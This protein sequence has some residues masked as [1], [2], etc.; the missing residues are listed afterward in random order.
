MELEMPP[1]P[2]LAPEDGCR[3]SGAMVPALA[4]AM[5]VDAAERRR[6]QVEWLARKL[7]AYGHSPTKAE[8]RALPCGHHHC[9]DG[10]AFCWVT[11]SEH[12]AELDPEPDRWRGWKGRGRI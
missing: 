6:R 9:R 3:P 4:L 11:A 7:A 5:A 10:C 2:P 1:S 12:A 8:G